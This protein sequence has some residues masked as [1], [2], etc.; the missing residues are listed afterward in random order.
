MSTTTQKYVIYNRTSGVCLGV[1][2]GETEEE[3]WWAC[4]EDAGSDEDVGS[5]LEQASGITV[6]TMEKWLDSVQVNLAPR[7]IESLMR[8][9]ANCK[10]AKIYHDG[11]IWIRGP[12]G[13]HWLTI[14]KISSFVIWVEAH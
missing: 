4:C 6:E 11:D 13:G 14:E 5:E 2:E 8:E 9:W 3:A 1:Y 7:T 12:Q 10:T